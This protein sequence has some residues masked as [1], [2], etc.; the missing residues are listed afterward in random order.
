MFFQKSKPL[1]P[2]Q[3]A[4]DPIAY[5]KIW[6]VYDSIKRLLHYVARED[7]VQN[8]DPQGMR[9]LVTGINCDPDPG[10]ATQQWQDIQMHYGLRGNRLAYHAVQSFQGYEVSPSTAHEIGVK[11]A[12]NL[13]GENYQVLVATHVD[14][15]DIHNQFAINPVSFIGAEKF[16]NENAFYPRMRALS[17]E[18]CKEYGLSIID[19]PQSKKGKSYA[20][21]KAEKEHLPT[22]RGMIREDVDAAIAQSQTY[23][24]FLSC[25]QRM[26]YEVNT[27]G[28]YHKIRPIGDERFF[29]LRSLDHNEGAYT[30]EAIIQRIL[31]NE[32]PAKPSKRPQRKTLRVRPYPVLHGLQTTWFIYIF[33]A[34]PRRKSRPRS[35]HTVVLRKDAQRLRQ[36]AAMCTLLFQRKITTL[37]QLAEY[38]L[39]LQQQIKEQSSQYRKTWEEKQRK[40]IGQQVK[41]LRYELRL[42]KQI[43]SEN[44]EVSRQVHLKNQLEKHMV[45]RTISTPIR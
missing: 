31:A 18:L 8:P 32:A 19:L 44:E 3:N 16:R 5:T 6:P 7:K 33:A 10:I 30:Q 40:A 36:R 34:G 42:C 23:Q 28:K 35:H 1:S 20:E 2:F 26:G 25:L 9:Q 17:D 45:S 27:R 29:R 4:G 43:A 37:S 24:Q 21:H 14:T 13:W 11:L 39:S 38:Q 12:T 41:R 15:D 22:K